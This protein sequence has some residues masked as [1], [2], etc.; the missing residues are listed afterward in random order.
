[1]P[2]PGGWPSYPVRYIVGQPGLRRLHNNA[3]QLMPIVLQKTICRS[4]F[5]FRAV[6]N[7]VGGAADKNL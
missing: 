5:G 7:P 6:G 3:R 2:A 4:P 1:M